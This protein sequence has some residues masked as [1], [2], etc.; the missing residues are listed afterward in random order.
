[1]TQ[2]P[3]AIAAASRSS[4]DLLD[5]LEGTEH[6]PDGTITIFTNAKIGSLLGGEE[7]LVKHIGNFEVPDGVRRW[8]VVGKIADLKAE[9]TDGSKQDQIDELLTEAEGLLAQ[10]QE[11]AV[12]FQLQAAPN[13]VVE[14]AG[15]C[16]H[17]SVGLEPH[18]TVPDDKL[19]EYGRQL[20]AEMLTRV[21][22]GYHDAAGNPGKLFD[23]ERALKLPGRLPKEEWLRLSRK[24]R[25]LQ[26][27]RAIAEQSTESADF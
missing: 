9:N 11:S 4:F 8:G 23:V 5:R 25:E 2:T 22:V 17:K 1:M 13:F 6:L 21:V 10:L 12:T 27:G 15:A 3:D 14:D 24:I 26:Y 18:E 19:E 16:A 7:Q 20:S